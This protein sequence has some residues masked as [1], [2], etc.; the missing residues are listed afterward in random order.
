MTF[1]T[2]FMGIGNIIGMPLALAIGRRLV[3]LLSSVVL[4]ISGILCATQKSYE[5]HL[6]ARMLLG[7]AAGQSE[8]L[9]PLMV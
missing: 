6:G 1:P 4:V 9:C 2:L 7:I 3:F 8:D 5:W